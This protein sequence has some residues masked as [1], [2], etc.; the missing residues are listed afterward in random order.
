MSFAFVEIGISKFSVNGIELYKTFIPYRVNDSQIKVLNIYDSNYVLVPVTNVSDITVGGLSYS[1][2]TNLINALHDVIFSPAISGDI[3]NTQIEANRLA[4]QELQNGQVATGHEHDDRY[5]TEDEIDLKLQSFVDANNLLSEGVVDG[6]DINFFDGNAN[7]AFT[8]DAKVFMNQGT[9]ITFDNGKL[10]LKNTDGEVLSEATIEAKELYYDTF[11]FQTGIADDLSDLTANENFT[12]AKT[13]SNLYFFV[14][15]KT[16]EEKLAGTKIYINDLGLWFDLS[17]ASITN[18]NFDAWQITIAEENF[19]VNSNYRFNLWVKSLEESGITP[20][21]KGDYNVA[22]DTPTLTN[23]TGVL[24]HEYRVT[25]ATTNGTNKDFGNGDVFLKDNDIIAFD[26]SF[27]FKKVNNN[28]DSGTGGSGVSTDADN[29]LTLGVDLKPYFRERTADEI[30]TAYESN[31]DTNA[32]TDAEKSKL[33]NIAENATADQT[34]AE[35]VTSINTELGS[36]TWQQ[37]GGP[38]GA[39]DASAVSVTP[40]GNLT[41]TNVEQALYELQSEVDVLNNE[42]ASSLTTINE[43]NTIADL[44][45]IDGAL[46]DRYAWVKG[47]ANTDKNGLYATIDDVWTMIYHFESRDI[48]IIKTG[49]NEIDLSSPDIKDGFEFLLTGEESANANYYLTNYIPVTVGDR[50]VKLKS[51]TFKFYDKDKNPIPNSDPA[52]P[53]NTFVTQIAIRHENV[54]YVRWNALIS[55]K[56]VTDSIV[57]FYNSVSNAGPSGWFPYHGYARDNSRWTYENNGLIWLNRT[58]NLIYYR[59]FNYNEYYDGTGTIQTNGSS[60]GLFRVEPQTPYSHP[61]GNSLVTF[62]DKSGVFISSLNAAIFNTPSNC[63][64]CS[65]Y[66]ARQS[67]FKAFFLVQNIKVDP[68]YYTNENSRINKEQTISNTSFALLGDSIKTE[69]ENYATNVAFASVARNILKIRNFSNV[70]RS[71]KT[72]KNFADDINTGYLPTPTNKNVYIIDLGTNDYGFNRPI[73]SVTDTSVTDTFHGHIKKI[74]ETIRGFGSNKTIAFVTPTKRENGDNEN[75]LGNTLRDYAD[76]IIEGCI[77][78]GVE[79]Y[80]IHKLAGLNFNNPELKNIYT[81]NTSDVPDGLHLNDLGHRTFLLTHAV[82]FYK[83]LIEKNKIS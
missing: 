11:D 31:I 2:A 48:P 67:D 79:Y 7:L 70:S 76:A 19:V 36:T 42:D 30:K 54:A 58:N 82:L 23:A 53:A 27:W 8:V 52:Y 55:D 66:L 71:G 28:Q 51:N 13:I 44:P 40:S 20:D 37:G 21:F 33:T 69:R 16:N 56:N 65:I 83:L 49:I 75:V 62:F 64:Y 46:I 41:S 43:Y 10:T 59:D 3:N 24:G 9:S 25:N 12:L 29:S 34:G 77:N 74:I 78:E 60:T 17:T 45:V 47:E 1:T 14:S 57:H 61:L 4:I 15:K 68:I 32:F 35:I 38:G 80:D 39:S 81:A 63:Y 18:A 72:M 22:T 73:G 26:G 6:S 50:L 5:Y